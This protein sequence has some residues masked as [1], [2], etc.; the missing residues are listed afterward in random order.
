MSLI[1][2][3]DRHEPFVTVTKKMSG[4]IDPVLRLCTATTK[5]TAGIPNI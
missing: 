5:N 1:D 3:V 4:K 2:F